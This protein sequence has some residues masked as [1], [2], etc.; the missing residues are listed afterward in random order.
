M[1][2]KAILAAL[3]I[4]LA[5]SVIAL[6][7][8]IGEKRGASRT[9]S[10][11]KPILNLAYPPPPKEMKSLSGNVLGVSEGIINFET[12]D[13]NDYLPHAD[14]TPQ[15]KLGRSASVGKGTKL[16]LIDYTK[17]DSKGNPKISAIQFSDIKAGDNIAVMS[18][19]NIRDTQKF[20]ATE[21]RVIKY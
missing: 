5:V 17:L 20:D 10:K 9:E 18:N 15:K 3:I 12:I 8:Y 1:R 4:L 2:S 19:E 13:F 6:S 21:V 16:S 7:L 11:L 14:N